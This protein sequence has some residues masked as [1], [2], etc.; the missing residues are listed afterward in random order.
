[1]TMQQDGRAKDYEYWSF[2][3][4]L[5]LIITDILEDLQD[6]ES[7]L[8]FSCCSPEVKQKIVRLLRLEEGGDFKE[9]LTFDLDINCLTPDRMENSAHVLHQKGCLNDFSA[10]NKVKSSLSWAASL[11]CTSLQALDLNS[12][13]RNPCSSR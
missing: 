11:F 9:F 1:M 4:T 5:T 10:Y 6:K 2:R 7:Y 12:I 3:K 13:C 8:E